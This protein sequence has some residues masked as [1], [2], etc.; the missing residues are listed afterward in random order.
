MIKKRT[1]TR[2][3]R[4]RDQIEAVRFGRIGHI[5]WHYLDSWFFQ[6]RRKAREKEK[7]WKAYWRWRKE[8]KPLKRIR[9]T[10]ECVLC[11]LLMSV[12]SRYGIL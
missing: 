7:R 12:I 5:S 4:E 1:H 3:E 8:E 6:N 9:R 2:R 11:F 10:R